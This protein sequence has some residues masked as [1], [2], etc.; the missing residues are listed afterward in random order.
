MRLPT[1]PPKPRDLQGGSGIALT[2]LSEQ[3]RWRFSMNGRYRRDRPLS[4]EKHGYEE[5]CVCNESCVAG[6]LGREGNRGRRDVPVRLGT[7][8]GG[9]LIEVSRKGVSD[10][11]RA[12]GAIDPDS[13]R[14][15]AGLDSARPGRFDH[16]FRGCA[17]GRIFCVSG[18][19]IR[20]PRERREPQGQILRPRRQHPHR[21][22]RP[23]LL[24]PRR[25]RPPGASV[26]QADRR[27]K[28]ARPAALVWCPDSSR[29]QGHL[30][31]R[32]DDPL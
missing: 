12:S 10:V 19:R 7:D 26:C 28:R 11:P 17:S 20:R 14:H 6:D 13:G 31:G 30:H 25:G 29:C 21:K 32:P 2:P 9:T 23:D 8:H 5:I 22:I 15:P 1:S 3:L 4:M 16:L 24:Q 27:A 18:G